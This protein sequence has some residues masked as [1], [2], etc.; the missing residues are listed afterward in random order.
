M[1]KLQNIQIS[2]FKSIS[3]LYP[4]SLDV[5]DVT[6][7]LGAN[8][9]GKSNLI[10]F[11]KMLN[12][13]MSGSF[14]NF[15][16]TNG[17]S[18]IF[19]HYGSKSTSEI[20]GSLTFL[21]GKSKKSEYKFAISYAQGDNLVITS[22]QT[23]IH[24]NSEVRPSVRDLEVNFKESVLVD[25]TDNKVLKV[26]RKILAGCKVYQFHD[27]SNTSAMRNSCYVEVNNY[28]QAEANNIAAFLYRIK[29]EFPSDYSRIVS[30]IKLIVPQF[31]D[32]YLEPVNNRILLKWVDDS[33]SD[34]IFLPHQ[35][36]DGSM[37]F[38]AMATLLLQPKVLMPKMIII[39]EPELGLHPYAITQLAEMIREASNNSQIIVATQ[40]TLLIDEFD[41][42]DIAVVESEKDEDK[43][44]TVIKRLDKSSF[45]VWMNDYTISQ[46]WEKNVFGG[47]PL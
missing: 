21:E 40:S 13:M 14:Q 5:G 33:G 43:Y 29:N 35:F 46:M 19:L 39:D 16:E 12:F 3:S 30:Y 2:G 26:M 42:N 37:R 20:K 27:S 41:L 4:V 31:G 7:I 28:L 10:S 23:A 25:N 1:A 38:I 6:I 17:G 36:S 15:I 8:G 22:E 9:S 11:F 24:F 45:E 32:F 47:R 18:Q 34:Y 44:H